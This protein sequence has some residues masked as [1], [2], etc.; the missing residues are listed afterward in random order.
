MNEIQ[1]APDKQ[2]AVFE[3]DT[4][5]KL[6]AFGEMMSKGS[7]TVPDHLK[8]NAADCTAVAM[9]AYQWGMNPYMVAQKTHL[10]SGTLGYEAQLVNAVV[11][12]STAINGRFHYEYSEGW[13]K[14]ADKVEIQSV[15]KKGRNGDYTV[16]MPVA[17]WTKEDEAGLWIRVGAILRGEDEIQWG[18]KIY[19]SQVLVRNS[20]LWVTHPAQQIA[21]LGVK[22]W[23][24][25]YTPAVILGVY[26]IDE[27]Q[28]EP[29]K[30]QTYEAAGDDNVSSINTML[31]DV[32]GER[33]Q[34]EPAAQVEESAPAET[35]A[36][37]EAE[38][39]AQAEPEPARISLDTFLEEVA[40]TE[41]LE[42]LEALE[43]F[44]S[45][46]ERGS[47]DYK[48]AGKAY[49]ARRAFFLRK[50]DDEN[51]AQAAEADNDKSAA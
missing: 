30:T 10:V 6:Q 42:Q 40:L 14:L 51:A 5:L 11:S 39:T 36:Q 13:E 45:S 31:K 1:A 24:R 22:H 12:S 4:I 50:Q 44:A 48:A 23:S 29:P 34:D 32:Q 35:E 37:P 20:P 21:Y 16:E 8:G 38:T 28:P 46:F 2:V 27:L 41:S 33:V 7:C 9:Q 19:L 49:K 15:K 47:D 18:E 43:Q 3:Q 26:T 17:T 25:V